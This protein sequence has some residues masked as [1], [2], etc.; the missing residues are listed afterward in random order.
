MGR[1]PSEPSHRDQKSL[2]LLPGIGSATAD[3]LFG[4]LSGPDFVRKLRSVSVPAASSRDWRSFRKAIAQ[5]HQTSKWPKD[6]SVVLKWYKPRLKQIYSTASALAGRKS[7]LW[8]L[9]NIA[10]NYPSRQAFLTDLTLDPPDGRVGKEGRAT[11]EE[12]YVILSTIHSAKGQE[13]SR[14]SILNAI[15]GCIPLSNAGN[16]PEAIEEERRV[17]HV[18]MTRAQNQLEI[19]VP[20]QHFSAKPSISS[21]DNVWARQT[22]FL[23]KSTWRYFARRKVRTT[24]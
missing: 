15:E 21:G 5:V 11:M 4:E 3:R 24:T 22:Q 2:K 19:L 10:A 18:A 20:R 7:D 13:Y 23:P 6:L 17:F 16:S 14:V 1:K 9:Q 12:A 8:Q